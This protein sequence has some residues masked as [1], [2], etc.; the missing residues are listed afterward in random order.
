MKYYER[1]VDLGCFTRDD[2]ESMTGNRETAHSVIEAYKKKGLIECVRRDLFVAISLETKQP[3][4]NR[5]AIAS[6]AAPSA[7]V[8][9]HSAFEYH[10][11]ANQVYYEA[12]VAANSRFR[13]FEH[14]GLVYRR[15]PSP[16]EDGVDTKADGTRVTNP[17]RTVIDGINDFDKTGG[18]EEL[19]RCI[20]MIPYLDSV[21]LISYLTCYDKVFLYQKAGYILEHFKDSLKLSDDFFEACLSKVP[22]SKRYLYMDLKRESLV[23]N[24][25]WALYVPEDLQA[26]TKKGAYFVE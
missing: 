5:F 4:P 13:T 14:N 12:Y 2:I 10:G 19:L 25:K 11:I 26:I 23:L 18:V 22:I 21:N 17:E 7:Y 9:Y 1:I 6:R 8:S 15:V 20:E 3:V 16:F 24:K